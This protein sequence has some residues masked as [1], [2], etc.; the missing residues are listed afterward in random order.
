M[1][2]VPL[3][4]AVTF[5][6]S[7]R[8]PAFSAHSARPAVLSAVVAYVPDAVCVVPSLTCNCCANTPGAATAPINPIATHTD[9][10]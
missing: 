6:P 10:R 8:L 7:M 9:N 4:V 1:H 2:T 5:A 3:V